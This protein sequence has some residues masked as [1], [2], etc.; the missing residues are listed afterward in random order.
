M[1]ETHNILVVPS[2]VGALHSPGPMSG[3]RAHAMGGRYL[4]MMSDTGETFRE[5][6]IMMSRSI[7]PRSSSNA[8]SN[9]SLSFSPKNVMSGCE[10]P[11]PRQ[12]LH[13]PGDLT[14]I[15]LH[16]AWGKLGFVGL[17]GLVAIPPVALS[18]LPSL[19]LYGHA[20]L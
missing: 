17:V 5:V 2:V 9:S 10:S 15:H 8:L 14:G 6:P 18:F 12:Q 7:S 16:D 3:R 13:A 4:P 20:R 1:R 19:A 11:S